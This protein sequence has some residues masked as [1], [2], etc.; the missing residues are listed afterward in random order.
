M[1]QLL[2]SKQ[3]I[4]HFVGTEDFLT[5]VYTMIL[6]VIYL[7]TIVI[8]YKFYLINILINYETIL[9]NLLSSLKCLKFLSLV[10][11]TSPVEQVLYP[12]QLKR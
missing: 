10:V 12:V 1:H 7:N 8:F 3:S 9:I 4:L 11:L 6:F 2:T 5:S